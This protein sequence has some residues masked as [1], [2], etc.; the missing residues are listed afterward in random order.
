[1]RPDPHPCR[2]EPEMIGLGAA[3][4]AA[5]TVQGF[6]IGGGSF[7]RTPVAEAAGA[8]TGSARAWSAPWRS[9]C[10]MCSRS[11]SLP[12]SAL[13]AVVIAAAMGL[14][15][16][17]DLHRISASSAGG[18]GCT[19]S[20]SLASQYSATCRHRLGNRH[21]NHGTSVGRLATT[22][23][24]CLATSTASSSNIKRIPRRGSF[25]AWCCSAGMRR[26]SSPMDE[27]FR[28]A[29]PRGRGAIASTG[30][31][32]HRDRRGRSPPSIDVTLGNCSPS[33]SRPC[34]N[35]ASRC[36]SRK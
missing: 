19:W 11:S 7:S 30:E 18:S 28:R 15:E 23:P 14:F 10:S 25:Q 17:N 24:R 36:A 22:L 3:N 26:S 8:G 32:D 2:P 4:L 6:P 31:R 16:H 12:N 13:A 29:P 27:L 33:W 35:R 34:A 5:G 1:M 21:R 9:R 20:P